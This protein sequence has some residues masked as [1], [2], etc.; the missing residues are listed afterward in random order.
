MSTP[1]GTPM[2][3]LYATLRLFEDGAGV[4]VGL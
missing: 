1:I 2:P 3:A 4:E